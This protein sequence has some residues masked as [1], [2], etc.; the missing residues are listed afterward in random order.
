MRH[1]HLHGHLHLHYGRFCCWYRERV[2]LCGLASRSFFRCVSHPFYNETK[3][4]K[5]CRMS[6]LVSTS[7]N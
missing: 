1:E 6:V 2:G 7:E 5:Y 3:N 4:M